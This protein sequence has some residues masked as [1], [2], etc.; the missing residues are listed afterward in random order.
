MQGCQEDSMHAAGDAELTCAGSQVAEKRVKVGKKH[1]WRICCHPPQLQLSAA[2]KN[3]PT[4]LQQDRIWVPYRLC[5]CRAGNEDGFCTLTSLIL[6][7]NSC[8]EKQF[9]LGI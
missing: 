3:K 9:R 6:T 4:G 7:I 5:A 2:D 8:P 1:S